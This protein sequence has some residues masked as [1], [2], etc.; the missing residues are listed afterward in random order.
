V[1][2][3]NPEAGFEHPSADLINQLVSE[4]EPPPSGGESLYYPP[5]MVGDFN[6][7]GEQEFPGFKTVFGDGDVNLLLIGQEE[8]FPSQCQAR[9]PPTQSLVIPFLPVDVECPGPPN[10][11]VSDHCGIFVAL[12]EGACKTP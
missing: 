4:L 2:N 8:S 3:V 5:L 11:A 10:I 7:I 6:S 9:I 12:E 1:F